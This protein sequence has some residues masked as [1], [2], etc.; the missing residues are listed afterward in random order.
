MSP[1]PGA[2]T[3][4]EPGRVGR[5]WRAHRPRIELLAIA[6]MAIGGIVC[7]ALTVLVLITRGS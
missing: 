4:A 6:A 3:A 5:W 2:N 1:E 7:M